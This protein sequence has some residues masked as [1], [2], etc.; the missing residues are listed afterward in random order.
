MDLQPND[1]FIDIRIPS[2]LINDENKF[3]EERIE[4]KMKEITSIYNDI[5]EHKDRIRMLENHQKMIED[6]LE[7]IQ[8]ISSSFLS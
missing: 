1:E 3:L 2:A 6:E 7:V 4:A 8:V 5:D